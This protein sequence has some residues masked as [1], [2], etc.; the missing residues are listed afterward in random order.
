MLTG[1]VPGRHAALTRPLE[2]VALVVACPGWIC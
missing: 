1:I 2:T